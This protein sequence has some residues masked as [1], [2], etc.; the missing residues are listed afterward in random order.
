MIKIVYK[1]NYGYTVVC[2][3][4]PVEYSTGCDT[5]NATETGNWI[6]LLVLYPMDTFVN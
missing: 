3:W 5:G 1:F 4:R 6:Y 2:E